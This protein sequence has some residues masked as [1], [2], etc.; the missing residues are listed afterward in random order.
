MEVA[1][2]VEV[3][4]AERVVVVRAVARAVVVR[5]VARAVEVRAEVA[6]VEEARVEG[7]EVEVVMVVVK[8]VALGVVAR[9]M[10]TLEEPVVVVAQV[11]AM[12]AEV[13]EG[14]ALAA[15]SVVRRAAVVIE[16]GDREG[17]KEVATVA[18]VAAQRYSSHCSRSRA[19]RFGS[20]PACHRSR[21]TWLGPQRMGTSSLGAVAKRGV[22]ASAA[23][24]AETT[25]AG[26]ELQPAFLWRP[27]AGRASQA[28][29]QAQL[30]NS[31]PWLR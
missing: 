2:A 5:A 12:A 25:V 27:M 9:A 13:R 22:V 19:H 26:K 31:L 3:R 14:V 18:T 10:A 30:T 21:C 29:R 16:A 15:T 17:E 24:L 4:A 1:R 6:M 11:V 28:L 20:T 8:V 23:A 7:A